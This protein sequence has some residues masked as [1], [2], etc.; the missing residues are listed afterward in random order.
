MKTFKFLAALSVTLISTNVIGQIFS[1]EETFKGYFTQLKN[2]SVDSIIIMRQGCIGCARKY[3]SNSNSKEKGELI[4]VLSK[5]FGKTKI[6]FIDSYTLSEKNTY[7]KAIFSFINRKRFIL[8]S[9]KTNLKNQN[10][11]TDSLIPYMY[12]ELEIFL[13]NY[14]SKTTLINAQ[15]I[16]NGQVCQNKALLQTVQKTIEEFYKIIHSIPPEPQQ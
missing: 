16:V 11:N 6:A 13:P 7:S 9:K 8:N 15:P 3:D 10:I 14:H 12:E 2:K 4:Y 5:K 1:S